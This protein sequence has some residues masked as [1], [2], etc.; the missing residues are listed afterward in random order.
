MASGCAQLPSERVTEISDQSETLVLEEVE[1]RDI[2]DAIVL[3]GLVESGSTYTLTTSEVGSLQHSESG[4]FFLSEN[5]SKIPIRLPETAVSVTPLVPLD[6]R[7]AE[8]LPVLQVQDAAFLFGFQLSPAEVMR[9]ANRMPIVAIAQI[10]GSEAPFECPLVDPQ[11]TFTGGAYFMFCRVPIGVLVVAGASGLAL[12]ELDERVGVPALPIEAVAGTLES[13]SV[14]LASHP[15]NAVPV[16]LGVT[17]GVYV[18]ILSG[19]SEGDQVVV[20][21]PSILGD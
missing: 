14:Y 4:Y 20:P 7:V 16:E 13:G 9:V 11:P 21:S 15:G 5:E 17:D 6:V 1:R 18:E 12:L 3:P 10:E 8:N 2:F 19:L